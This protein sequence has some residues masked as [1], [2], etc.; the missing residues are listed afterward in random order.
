[1]DSSKLSESAKLLEPKIQA[2]FSK[3]S[4]LK[5]PFNPGSTSLSE[6]KQKLTRLPVSVEKSVDRLEETKDR[7]STAK[8]TD[9]SNTNKT[10]L[11][12]EPSVRQFQARELVK[13]DSSLTL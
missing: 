8:T 5:A 6:H 11:S 9:T 3:E 1:M 12:S 13:T 10:A 2:A 7:V 4:L